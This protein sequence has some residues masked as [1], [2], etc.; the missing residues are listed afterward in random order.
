MGNSFTFM[1]DDKGRVV[2]PLIM[3]KRP[4]KVAEWTTEH[5]A[6]RLA[7]AKMNAVQRLT[8]EQ[9]APMTRGISAAI[10]TSPDFD[11]AARTHEL[12]DTQIQGSLA[13]MAPQSQGGA[14]GKAFISSDWRDRDNPIL[15]AATRLRENVNRMARDFMKQ[16]ID[17][18]FGGQLAL[19]ANP[20]NA[21]SK[22]L[23]NQ[24][25]SFRAG[26]DIAPKASK[27]ADGFHSFTLRP[28][29]DNAERFKA[30]F[31][32]E[33]AKNQVFIQPN[34]KEVVLDDLGDGTP[35]AVQSGD[36]RDSRRE[37]HHPAGQWSQRDSAA[38]LVCSAC[39]YG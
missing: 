17:K 15:L 31:G 24:F 14:F 23:L 6:E 21:T 27:R 20:R 13:G 28:T 37:E 22:L 39:E 33:M 30:Q 10:M 12:L 25:H 16:S 26:W 7:A 36:R 18:A 2:K 4:F 38:G 5:N 11:A 3:Y 35:D 8:D 34:G 9:A 32:R 19:L 1:R 29:A